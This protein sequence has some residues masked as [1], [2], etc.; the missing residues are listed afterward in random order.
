MHSTRK[1]PVKV[2]DVTEMMWK[3]DNAGA[4]AQH[5]PELS[6][7]Y[8]V[9]PFC[10]FTL[11]CINKLVGFGQDRVIVPLFGKHISST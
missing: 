3:G 1:T 5:Y 10:D 8:E 9:S 2:L 6:K 4:K 7:K 11:I